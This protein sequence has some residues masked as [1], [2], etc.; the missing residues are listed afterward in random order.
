MFSLPECTTQW[1]RQGGGGLP[2]WSEIDLAWYTIPWL[3]NVIEHGKFLISYY[4]ILGFGKN[5]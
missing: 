4:K 3:E 2:F 1:G 5:E